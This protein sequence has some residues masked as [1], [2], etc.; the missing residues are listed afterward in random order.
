MRINTLEITGVRNIREVT[1]ELGGNSAFFFGGNGAGKTSIVEAVYVLV[2]GKSFRSRRSGDWRAWGAEE[3]SVSADLCDGEGEYAGKWALRHRGGRAEREATGGLR[4]RVLVD[5]AA[6]LLQGEPALRRGFLDMNLFHVEPGAASVL[7]RFRRALAQRNAWLRRGGGGR[8]VWDE[9]FVSAALELDLLRNRLFAELVLEVEA[10]GGRGTPTGELSMTYHRGWRVGM[11]LEEALRRDAV[12]E[13]A[14][15]FTRLGPQRADFMVANPKGKSGWS[16]GQE[17]L[18]VAL[19]QLAL[20]RVQL[21]RVGVGSVWLLDDL[22]SGLDAEAVKT[23]RTW[24]GELGAQCL[25]TGA[26]EDAATEWV[27]EA[28]GTTAFHVEQGTVSVPHPP[29]IAPS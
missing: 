17:K 13:S 27:S 11:S 29:A 6:G 12:T 25:V 5:G 26:G 8:R 15:G 7:N 23:V 24:L 10:I 19:L 16:R 9:E 22:C 1:V 28:G 4:V 20:E 21:R 14:A 3:A 2:R 18:I